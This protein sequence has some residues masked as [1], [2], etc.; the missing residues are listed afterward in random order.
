MEDKKKN[1]NE[2]R[3][4][5]WASPVLFSTVASFLFVSSKF[6]DGQNLGE[7]AWFVY[8]AGWVSLILMALWS[9]V[10]RKKPP[11]PAAPIGFGFAVFFGLLELLFNHEHWPF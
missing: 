6:K 5:L 1:P 7:L 9:L 3:D 11:I 10:T 4:S 2:L 8:L